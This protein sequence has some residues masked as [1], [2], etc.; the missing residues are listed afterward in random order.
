MRTAVLVACLMAGSAM[1]QVSRDVAVTDGSGLRVERSLA[2]PASLTIGGP[3][4]RAGLLWTFVDSVSITESVALG[5]GGAESWVGHALNDERL[6]KF[7]TTGSGVPDF[8]YSMVDENPSTVGVAAA[9]DGS[10]CAVISWPGTAPIV[11]RAF[12]DAGGG[13]PV[14]SYAFGGSYVNAHK[15]AVA[16]NADGSRVAACAY[17]GAQTLLV[18]LDGA[19]GSVLGSATIAGYCQGVEMDD[20]G[21]R[22]VVTA[23][24]T[25]RLFDSATMTEIYSLATSGAGGYH[26][27]SRDGTAIAAGG[28]NIRAAREVGGVWQV[29]YA[30]SGSTDWFGQLALSGDGDTL[31]VLSHDYGDGYL[32][33]EHRLVDL[34]TGT[35][36]QRW[37]YTGSGSF[38]NSAVAAQAND[39]GTVFAAAS[40]GDEA[41]TQPEVRVFDRDLNMIGS[42]DTE[43]SPFEMSMSRDGRFVLVG[44]K[45]VHANTFGSGG[46][47]YA[48]ELEVGCYADFNGDGS[49]NTQDVLAFLNAWAAADS[50]ADCNGDGNINTQDVLCFLNAWTSGC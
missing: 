8:V 2:A 14:W 49:V 13:T 42:I 22:I 26:R 34:T 19:T 10:K 17:D 21:D 38:Q 35:E 29:A 41:N 15:R 9:M 3:V 47:T 18:L 1:G 28:F 30:G 11:V 16:V 25:A 12:T 39:D 6:S 31:F 33:D 43:G 24:A 4:M 20:A 48:Y 40:W 45:A 7:T 37:S 32:T 44:S 36:L 50:S 46:R 23:G 5:G 27:I